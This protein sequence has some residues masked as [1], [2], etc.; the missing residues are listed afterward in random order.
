MLPLVSLL[1]IPLASLPATPLVSLL[2][3][4]LVILL[5]NQHPI[6]GY[7]FARSMWNV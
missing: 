5:S 6:E 3:S 4:L 1:A 2:A 7:P